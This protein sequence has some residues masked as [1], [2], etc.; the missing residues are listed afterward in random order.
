MGSAYGSGFAGGSSSLSSQLGSTMG[1]STQ[2]S[3]LAQKE[4]MYSTRASTLGA[5]ADLGFAA[6]GFASK[7]I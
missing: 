2:M 6:S 1:Y 5:V 4:S 3:G 7:F